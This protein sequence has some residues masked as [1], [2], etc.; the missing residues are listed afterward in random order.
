[1]FLGG[2]TSLE[3]CRSFAATWRRFD[4]VCC[5]FGTLQR[6]SIM[7]GLSLA[8][9]QTPSILGLVTYLEL[10]LT[11]RD[12]GG[13]GSFLFAEKRT[14]KANPAYHAV[15]VFFVGPLMDDDGRIHVFA[16][17]LNDIHQLS[18]RMARVIGEQVGVKDISFGLTRVA[19]DKVH[20]LEVFETLA[21]L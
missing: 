10:E 2:R 14:S 4:S 18:L 8:I 19:S 3:L 12:S 5:L 20:Q 6:M 17:L 21:L 11:R 15:I 7:S 9:Q 13:R 1:M 16:D